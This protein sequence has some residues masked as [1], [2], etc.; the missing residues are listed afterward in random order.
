MFGNAKEICQF[1]ANNENVTFP[2]QFC[3]RSISN[4]LG[5]SDSKEVSLK[6]MY[7]FSVNYNVIDKSDII[8]IHKYLMV[9][10]NIK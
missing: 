3:V 6:N 1:K 4:G 7:H 8:N 2:N 9:K 5:P 10:N